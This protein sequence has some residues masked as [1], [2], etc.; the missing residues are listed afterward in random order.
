M[1]SFQY[2]TLV[3]CNPPCVHGSCVDTNMCACE[4]SYEGDSC[5]T[6]D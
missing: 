5:N 1:A 4:K 3:P 6:T 2:W